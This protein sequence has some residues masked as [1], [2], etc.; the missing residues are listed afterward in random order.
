M[1]R[2]TEEPA[3]R[4]LL[5]GA[6]GFLGRNVILH[7]PSDLDLTA[8]YWSSDDF[9]RFVAAT[10]RPRLACVRCNLLD[11]DEVRQRLQ[12]SGPF[13]AILHLAANPDARSSVDDPRADL[14]ANVLTTINLLKEV[15]CRRFLYFSSGSVYDGLS[16]DVSPES[17]L[18][19]RFPY[20]VSKA[21]AEQYVKALANEHI[22]VRFFGAYGPY[23]R[24]D[25]IHRRILRAFAFGRKRKFTLHG[26]GE[27]LISSMYVRDAVA[28][29]N[30]FLRAKSADITVDFASP[31]PVT[32][33]E[34]VRRAAAVFGQHDVQIEHVEAHAEYL[35]IRPTVT[36]VKEQFGFLPSISLEDGFRE[37]AS[38]LSRIEGLELPA[39]RA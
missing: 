24:E 15:D 5:T 21:C 26:D 23:E 4:V 13:D 31:E 18:D 6:S 3:L 27:N 37:Y 12:S 36:R 38:E 8:V 22:I 29:M 20:A 25:K 2:R 34:L 11:V 28:G 7:S 30:A 14:E 16:G 1:A 32:L 33:N 17:R 9:P 10:R 35:V 19:P 39:R